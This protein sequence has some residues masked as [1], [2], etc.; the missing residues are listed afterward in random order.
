MTK[1]N[2]T[3]KDWNSEEEWETDDYNR[4]DSKR[5]DRKKELVKAERQRKQKRNESFFE[6]E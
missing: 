4:R 3:F 2:K 1:K 5:Y 6:V